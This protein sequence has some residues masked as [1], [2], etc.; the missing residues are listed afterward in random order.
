MILE[1]GVDI[2]NFPVSLVDLDPGNDLMRGQLLRQSIY[3]CAD[4]VSELF[5]AAHEDV[6]AH[7]VELPP[8]RIPHRAPG[9]RHDQRPGRHVPA[10]DAEVEVAVGRARS[11]LCS[12]YRV[13]LRQNQWVWVPRRCPLLQVQARGQRGPAPSSVQYITVHWYWSAD[14]HLGEVRQ[15]H[16]LLLLVRPHRQFHDH[17]RLLT[18]QTIW[19]QLEGNSADLGRVGDAAGEDLQTVTESP[20]PPHL[21]GTVV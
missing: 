8:G 7:E 19:K 5:A 2:L 1:V 11:N 3:C 9:L 6:P 20:S 10:V 4:L 16:P 18:S 21:H 17:H 13:H 14:P 12:I 15:R